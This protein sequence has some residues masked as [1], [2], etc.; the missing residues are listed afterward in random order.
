[1]LLDSRLGLTAPPREAALR[2]HL[3]T[4]EACAV[5]ARA[6]A[7]LAEALGALRVVPPP[8]LDVTERVMIAVRSS[9]PETRDEVPGRQLGW[10][11]AVAVAMS[12]L[13]AAT[14]IRLAPSILDAARSGIAG[15]LGAGGLALRIGR[16]LL[17]GL[18]GGGAVPRAVRD[19]AQAAWALLVEARPLVLAV[20]ALAGLLMLVLSFAIVGRDLGRRAQAASSEE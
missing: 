10:A 7:A 8:S 13:A 19:V 20:S 18:G 4:C 14:G 11:L 17:G 16:I 12:V 1:M 2:E 3:A 9:V 5:E 15:V 6:E